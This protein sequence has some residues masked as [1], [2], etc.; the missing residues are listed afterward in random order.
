MFTD[1]ATLYSLTITSIILKTANKLSSELFSPENK[2]EV[3]QAGDL[4]SAETKQQNV[5]E[6]SKTIQIIQT[7]VTL[8]YNTHI[9]S[10]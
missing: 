8:A 3:I 7:C 1:A 6:Q 5:Y 4:D 9:T 2:E 10:L